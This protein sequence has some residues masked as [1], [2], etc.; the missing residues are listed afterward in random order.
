MPFAF[1]EPRVLPSCALCMLLFYT[2]KI[3]YVDLVCMERIMEG[4]YTQRLDHGKQI[5]IPKYKFSDVAN[6][7]IVLVDES[8]YTDCYLRTPVLDSIH[9]IVQ[10]RDMMGGL[11]REVRT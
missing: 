4:A 6:E 1:P 10:P 5:N 11:I 8:W 9:V 7:Y 3:L 2:P